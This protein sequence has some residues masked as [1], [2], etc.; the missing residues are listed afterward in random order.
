MR[1]RN[2]VGGRS[3]SITWKGVLVL[4]VASFCVGL[5]FTNRMWA[6]PEF[7]DVMRSDCDPKPRS[8][9]GDGSQAEIMDE[10]TRTHQ[11]IQTLDKTI[12]SLEAELA[13][14]RSEK[15]SGEPV[16]NSRTEIEHQSAAE[17]IEGRQKAFVVIGINTA[18]SSRKR[19]DSVRETWM[20]QGDQ[21]RKLE[22]EKGIVMRFVIGHS[23]TPGGILDRAIEAEDAQHNDF[24]RLDHV[25]G[26]HE[27]SMK[28][29]IYFSTAVKKWDAEFYVKVDDDVHVNVGMLATTLSR[30]RSKPRVYIGCMKSGPVLA[31][32]GV[33]YHE[34]EY[35]KFG[36]EGNKYFR[37]ATGQIYAISKDLA[38][39]ID[40]NRP[41]LHKYANEDVSLGA[42][43]IGL[44][45]DHI[46]DRSMCCGT[47]PDCEWKAQAGNVCVASFDWTCSGIC[48]SVERMNDVHQ[49]CGEGDDAL[50]S[51]TI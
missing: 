20:P 10:V 31:Q 32:K 8:G 41:L 30:H 35:W 23:A 44:D 39:Y 37:H 5:L 46:D 40:V 18:F 26:Y 29:K 47:P 28:T 42:W 48:K 38:T 16:I 49:R 21:L 7:S 50:W 3:S 34:P 1:M 9:N 14:A 24:L 15:A 4:C 45:V 17:P 13:A 11:V 19:R 43:I 2:S 51:T 27:L 22:K 33:K 12:A 6:S 25:E 36:E